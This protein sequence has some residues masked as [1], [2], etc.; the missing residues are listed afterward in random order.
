MHKLDSWTALGAAGLMIGALLACKKDKEEPPPVA[1]A[2][3]TAEPPKEEKKEEPKTEK[4][5]EVKRYGSKEL[6]GGGTVRV[7]SHH[8]KVYNEAD[9]STDHVATLNRGTLVN[10]KA[11][12]GNF[13]LVDYPTGPGELGP[14]WVRTRH[15]ESVVLKI[16][17]RRSCSRTPV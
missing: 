14:G 8:A 4:K 17:P 6:T 2:A 7:K 3:P 12:Y 11:R 13:L 16:D 15:L 10:R 9:E 5:D 1:S